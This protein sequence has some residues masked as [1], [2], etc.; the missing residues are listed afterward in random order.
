MGVPDE[1]KLGNLCRQDMNR[2]EVSA[3]SIRTAI[4]QVNDL[5]GRDTWVGHA[6]D[7]W[8]TDLQG[9]MGALGRLFNS[10]PAE[11]NRLVSE[12]QKK[13]AQMSSPKPG[14]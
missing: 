2:I 7:V 10:F 8:G 5:V 12:A 3:T 11:E 9:R 4:K 1:D 13:Q 14:G 6:A